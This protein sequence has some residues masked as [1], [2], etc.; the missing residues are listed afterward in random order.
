MG[1]PR[2]TS[3]DYYTQ[4]D[5]EKIIRI[6]TMWVPLR[7]KAIA[8]G[9]LQSAPIPEFVA[10]KVQEIARHASRDSKWINARNRDIMIDMAVCETLRYIHG[11]NPNKIGERSNKVNFFSY[12]TSGVKHYFGHHT[13]A[14]AEQQY[15][16]DIAYVRSYSTN[17]EG[18]E[19]VF[20]TGDSSSNVD[21]TDIG[22]DISERASRFEQQISERKQR[23]KERR[24]AK[25]AKKEP[26]K[27]RYNFL[28]GNNNEE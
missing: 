19:G 28:K 23:S 9:N 26:K 15:F 3:R 2:D 16:K 14:E 5:D 4:D 7:L 6:M 25:M 1:R 18:E 27:Q 24:A 11:F 21:N 17:F 12:V 10:L 13:M 8:E 22:R 20:D